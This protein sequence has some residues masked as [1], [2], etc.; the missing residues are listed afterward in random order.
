M[1]FL[2]NKAQ[3]DQSCLI[4]G[5]FGMFSTEQ[6]KLPSFSVSIDAL[7]DG[8]AERLDLLDSIGDYVFYKG[9]GN[10]L[11]LLYHGS[12]LRLSGDMTH[13][14][15]FL[16]EKALKGGKDEVTYLLM[17]AY[18]YRLVDTGSFMIHSAAA[19]FLHEGILFCGVSGAGKSSQAR[20]W[21]KYLKAWILNFDKPCV[22]PG[23]ERVLVHG[24][25][26]SGKEGYYKN[27]CVPVKAA[28]FVVQAEYNRVER[29]SSSEAYSLLF[30]HN[31]LYPFT[32]DMEKKYEDVIAAA[33]ERI[34]VYKLYCDLSE[35]AV[36]TLY[37]ELFPD[38]PYY[39]KKRDVSML[40]KI[41]N[42]FVM[43]NIAGEHVVIPRGASAVD[44]GATLVF[45]E[46]GAFL[47]K[48]LLRF[49]GI[50]TLAEELSQEFSIDYATAKQDVSDLIAKL[51]ENDMIEEKSDE[52]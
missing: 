46:T 27:R 22:L 44:F 24:S 4:D 8:P 38:D 30:L 36:I 1:F 11:W 18:M 37:G 26:W 6:T 49:T 17:Q 31:Y 25:P 29:L 41:K 35:D 7:K 19:V 20:L 39:D 21:K 15:V 42:N 50:D 47:W 3:Y 43:K 5:Q 48:K 40:Y 51:R 16:S 33:A 2:D 52:N 28:V 14:D 9:E 12:Y 13:A 45:N 32:P 34:P 10:E 23:G